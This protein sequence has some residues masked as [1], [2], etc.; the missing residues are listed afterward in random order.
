MNY[1]EHKPVFIISKICEIE[2]QY[3]ILISN[4]V[5]GEPRM[6]ACLQ[7]IICCGGNHQS[8]IDPLL[9]HTSLISNVSI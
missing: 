9:V 4:H 1:I 8:N 5:A 3:E 7:N 6:L 2:R